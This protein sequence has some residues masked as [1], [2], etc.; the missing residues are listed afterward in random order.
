MDKIIAGMASSHALAVVEPVDW[1]RGREANR[2]NY[3]RRYGVKPPLHPKAA[4]ENMEVREKRYSWVREGLDFL[5]EKLKEKKPDALVLIGDDQDENFSEDNW[6]QI[7]IY[8]GEEIFSTTR[9]EGKRE[10]GPRYRCHSALAKDL[11]HGLVERGFDLSYS[12][13]FPDSELRSHA[14]CQILGRLLP[15]TDIPIVPIFVNATHPP[16]I[17]P[18]RCYRLGQTIREIVDQRSSEDRVAIYASGGN[19]HFPAGFPW[20]YYKGPFTYGSISEEF[21]RNI[22][23]QMAGGK[24]EKLAQLSSQDLIENGN[25]EMRSWIVLLGIMGKTLPQMLTYEALYSAGTGMGVAYWE[26]ENAVA[27]EQRIHV[28]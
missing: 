3:E 10:R 25:D 23:K 9:R 13:S 2:V 7:A 14:H 5:Q 21:D 28:G 27:E 11:L 1:D 24:G 20:K 19:S 12:K 15:E 17:S 4:E 16:I 22:M 8:L 26:L 18:G 6:P